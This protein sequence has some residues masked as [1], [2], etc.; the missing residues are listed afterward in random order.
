MT[1][2]PPRNRI[3]LL[4]GTN[5]AKKGSRQLSRRLALKR[6][7]PSRPRWSLESPRSTGVLMWLEMPPRT[8]LCLLRNPTK[9]AWRRVIIFR[10]ISSRAG[11]EEPPSSTCML[12]MSLVWT[13]QSWPMSAFCRSVS[14]GGAGRRQLG[15][16]SWFDD[17]DEEEEAGILVSSPSAANDDERKLGSE[18]RRS[19]C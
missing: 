10:P 8:V 1:W 18:V 6:E 3:V 12:W 16:G 19:Y 5:S 14:G 2:R 15:C 7:L 13:F 11:W 17:D 4:S 9:K